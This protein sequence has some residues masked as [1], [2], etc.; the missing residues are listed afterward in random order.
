[1]KLLK[2]Y[3]QARQVDD[4]INITQEEK[5]ITEGIKGDTKYDKICIPGVSFDD[6]RYEELAAELS[7]LKEHNIELFRKI[8]GWN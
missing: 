3:L 4:N 1:M 6:P 8:I 2:S 5:I 7:K